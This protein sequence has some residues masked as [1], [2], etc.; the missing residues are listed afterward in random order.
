M[1]KMLWQNERALAELRGLLR[2]P[3]R[4]GLTE[5]ECRGQIGGMLF[6][7]GKYG[8]SISHLEAGDVGPE[9]DRRRTF[10]RLAKELPYFRTQ[11]GALATELP[12]V[13]GSLPEL[14]CS[15]GDKRR[16]FVLDSGTT[17]T[18]LSQSLAEELQVTPILP[19]GMTTHDNGQTFPI[20]VGVLRNFA[21]GDVQLGSVPVLVVEDHRLTMRDL[22][23]GAEQTLG[24]V[25]GMDLLS[26]F[27]MT[28]D[29]ERE[30][31][32]LE[33]PRGLSEEE[34]VRCLW[35]REGWV[36]PV[37]IEGRHL[38]FILDTG[39]SHSSLT[40][41]GLAAVPDGDRRTTPTYRRVRSAGGSTVSVR[42][43]TN[44][45]LHV[46]GNRFSGVEL[47]LVPRNTSGL[48][49]IH[50]VLGADLLLLCRLTLDS[51]RLRLEAPG[52][53]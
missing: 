40:Q 53:Q 21:L 46:A 15:I 31:V 36:V 9:A 16:T 18:T 2:T 29:L 39:A 23:G 1:S 41:E 37:S 6:R 47:P 49:P 10:A 24:G 25:V 4:A 3:D 27:R 7:V 48:F 34:S 44:L 30:S 8:E 26:I 28:L 13:K 14:V 5:A 38:W 20:S 32:V 52:I 51:G 19:M 45:V 17:M 50:G 42:S 22:F 11:V 43:L 35:L 33:L 12:L